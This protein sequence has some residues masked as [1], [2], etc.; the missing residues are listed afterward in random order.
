M[1]SEFK[2]TWF[3][4]RRDYPIQVLF[5]PVIAFEDLREKGDRISVHMEAAQ[6]S[7]DGVAAL[8]EQHRA[9]F[10]ADSEQKQRKPEL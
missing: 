7:M 5:G 6:R 1:A 4:P 8:A 2:R 9:M 3:G 10:S